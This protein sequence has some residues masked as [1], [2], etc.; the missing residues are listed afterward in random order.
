MRTFYFPAVIS[1][2]FFLFAS[3]ILS[4]SRLDVYHT[5]TLCGLSANLECRSEMYCT[6]LAENTESKN[7]PPAYHINAELC[8]AISS[9]LRHA[10]TIAK[11]LVK[12]QYLIHMS[13]Q[14]GELTAEIGWRVWGNP[15]NFNGF[16][17][18]PSLLHWR[19][20]SLKSGPAKPKSRDGF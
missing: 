8:Q 14:Y 17:V 7:S 1:C 10:L 2:S 15:A 3:P 13:S 5:S 6:R 4:G 20:P 12:Q 16:R 11:K 19:R 9:H 18:L